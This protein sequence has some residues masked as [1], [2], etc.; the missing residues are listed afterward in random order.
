MWETD[1]F[2]PEER[3]ELLDGAILVM[4]GIGPPHADG[5]GTVMMWFSVRVEGRALV[6]CQDA[7][8]LTVGSALEPD[9]MV[10][11]P[12]RDRYRTRLPEPDD[13]LLLI[14][15]ADTSLRFDR[16]L[17]L[18]QYAAVGIREVWIVDLNGARVLVYRE[19][20]D[21]QYTS[22][23]IVGRGGVLSPLAFP[24]LQLPVDEV[25]G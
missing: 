14:E 10:L 16:G 15:V 5:V 11:Q 24:D 17:K 23:D 2:H 19:P 25:L 22:T 13:V 21:G 20:K 1:I 18:Q 9:L 12:P 3:L 6:R 8:R 7:V 4:P